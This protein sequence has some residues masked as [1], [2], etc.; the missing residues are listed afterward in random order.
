MN[1]KSLSLIAAMALSFSAHAHDCSGGANG[2]MDATGNQCNDMASI[3]TL[4]SSD[5]ATVPAAAMPAA[6]KGKSVSHTTD[7]LKR[8]VAVRHPSTRSPSKHS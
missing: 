2:G 5:A 1:A 7:T 6:K 4:V 8:T 3:A